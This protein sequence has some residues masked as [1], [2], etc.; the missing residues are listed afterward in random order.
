M[1]LPICWIS[2]SLH[3]NWIQRCARHHSA[4]SLRREY[5]FVVKAKVVI[6]A[7]ESILAS[8]REDVWMIERLEWIFDIEYTFSWFYFIFFH[9]ILILGG[10]VDFFSLEFII[11]Y[12]LFLSSG[13]CLDD[14]MG[15]EL[16]FIMSSIHNVILTILIWP[17][18][19]D[20][21][22]KSN[23]EVMYNIFNIHINLNS[24]PERVL[25]LIAW[26]KIVETILK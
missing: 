19:W 22:M 9:M 15:Q 4:N 26:S 2:F 7:A 18:G 11:S 6:Y 21:A 20:D 13:C 14:W 23:I 17:I 25:V 8:V 16:L 12:W 10:H 1:W 5:V 24:I 3:W